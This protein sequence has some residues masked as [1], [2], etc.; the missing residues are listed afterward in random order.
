MAMLLDWQATMWQEEVATTHGCSCHSQGRQGVKAPFCSVTS[1]GA[2]SR[3]D[4]LPQDLVH[5][6]MRDQDRVPRIP[7]LRS[8]LQRTG[9]KT[10]QTKGFSKGVV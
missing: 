2:Y 5:H 10:E 7:V 3:A 8:W 6:L 9:S 1:P 4:L